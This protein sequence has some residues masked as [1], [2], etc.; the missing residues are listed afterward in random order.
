MFRIDGTDIEV[1]RGDTA[2]ITFQVDNYEFVNGDKVYFT[3]KRNKTDVETVVQKV[4]YTFDKNKA[5]IELRSSDTNIAKGKYWYDIQC[6]LADGR[7]D[8]VITASRFIVSEEI[9]V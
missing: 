6:N 5:N 3:V 2:I 1:T 7:V 9:T 4:I 8:T